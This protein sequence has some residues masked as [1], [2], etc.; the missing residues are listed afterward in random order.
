[1]YFLHFCVKF[2]ALVFDKETSPRPHKQKGGARTGKWGGA[3]LQGRYAY[4]IRGR[5]DSR[6]PD[7]MVSGTVHS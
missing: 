2:A 5:G 1:M 7:H 4:I 3:W 6:I